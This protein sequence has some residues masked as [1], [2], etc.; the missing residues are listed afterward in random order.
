MQDV[1]KGSISW[2]TWWN[3]KSGFCTVFP[4]KYCLTFDIWASYLFLCGLRVEN[5]VHFKD[6]ALSFAEHAEAG[7]VI[8]VRCHHHGLAL[9]VLVLLQHW[10]HTA[11]HPDV[12]WTQ[13]K[14]KRSTSQILPDAVKPYSSAYLSVPQAARGTS[15]AA[16][17]PSCISPEG[18]CWL[19]TSRWWLLKSARPK[20]QRRNCEF[21]WSILPNKGA[22]SLCLPV[23]LH[24]WLLPH[25][26]RRSFEPGSSDWRSLSSCSVKLEGEL[27]D[28]S[29]SLKR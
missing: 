22:T 29:A 19:Q 27:S 4:L 5:L 2:K 1:T 6:A 8:R 28:A 16:Q 10:F 9:F 24:R 17:P 13:K 12:A 7:L 25:K 20:R 14:K 18:L 3:T 26:I 15:C 23:F 11:Q 21:R